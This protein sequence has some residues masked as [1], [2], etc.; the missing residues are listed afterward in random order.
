MLPQDLNNK[1]KAKVAAV[2]HPREMVVDVM[3]AIQEH[4]GYLTDEGVEE[5]A[6]LVGMSPLEVEQLATFYTFVYREPVG[7]YVIHVC[8]SVVC[9]MNG[10]ESIR[11]YLSGKL[12]I[13]DGE[14]TAD[15]LFTLLPVCCVG[16]C[17][18]S[19]AILINKKVYGNLTTEKIDDIFENLK[20]EMKD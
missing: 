1:L 13:Q 3:F 17:D 6:R 12:G 5:T 8:D 16:Y 11:D 2:D 20:A 18:R 10:F 15:G 4:Y 9:W 14:T 19:P 7:K